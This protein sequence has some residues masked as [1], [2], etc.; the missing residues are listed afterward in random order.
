MVTGFY[1]PNL[2][3]A[4]IPLSPDARDS[5]LAQELANDPTAPTIVYVTL[6]HTAEACAEQLIRE[7][8]NARAYHAGLDS[9]LRSQIQHDFM[10]GKV[11]CIVA[12]IAFGMGIDKADIRR[13]I[14]YDLPKS[15]ENYSQRLAAPD[16]MANH[17]AVS[18]WPTRANCR[19]WRTS[20]TVIRR[21]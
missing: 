1:R 6:Q 2:D 4:V 8:I 16:G 21:I 10:A 19:C 5:W 13:V 20:S 18:C 15:I 11:D 7:G 14:H 12:T 3:L 17:R 9:A